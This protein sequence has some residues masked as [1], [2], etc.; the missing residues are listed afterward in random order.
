[1]SNVV[2][3]R[4]CTENSAFAVTKVDLAG[5]SETIFFTREE[6]E[7]VRADID[8]AITEYEDLERRWDEV[9]KQGERK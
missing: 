6:I 8:E 5:C 3:C 9:R 7:S 1:M 2:Y 4:W